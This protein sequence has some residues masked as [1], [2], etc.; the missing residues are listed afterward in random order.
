MFD[1]LR[2]ERAR[3]P[4]ARIA[5]TLCAAA[6]ATLTL[7]GAALAQ[8]AAFLFP[9][10]INDQ[11]WNAQGYLGAEKLKSLGW[12]ISYSENV[13]AADM[14]DALRDYARQGNNV[15]IGH[16]GRFVSA[17]ERVGPDFPKTLFLVGSGSKGAAPNVT[18]IDYDNTQFG[19]LMGVLAARMSKTGKIGS[20]N[21]LEGIPNVTAQVGAFRLGAKSVRPDI[22]VKVI[23]IK[24]M[25]D[26]AEAKEATLSLI[27]G[28]ADF[29]SGKLNAAQSGIIQAAKEKNVYANGRSYGHTE[30]APDNVLTNIVEK[31]AD[32]YTAAAEASKTTD[33]GGK[34][35]LYGFNTPGSTGAEL[36]YG[37]GQAYNKVVPKAVV[38]ELDGLKKKFASGELKISVTKEDARG[39]I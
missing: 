37:E 19:Y 36:S 15:V 22:E 18:S 24:S 39:G 7:T 35:I 1:A 38:D 29:I 27:A 28:G 5:A 4:R 12:Q 34:Y 21:S 17:A 23:Y 20:V 8:K 16:T 32:M 6:V 13:G 14:V 11:S 26:A 10:S 25:E 33:M 2:P 31:W 3:T 30:I 9:G